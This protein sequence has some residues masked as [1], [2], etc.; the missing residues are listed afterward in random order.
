MSEEAKK[1]HPLSKEGRALREQEK[2][3]GVPNDLANQK[4]TESDAI[5]QEKLQ[6]VIATTNNPP[7][8]QTTAEESTTAVQEANP[9]P[10]VPLSVVQQMINDALKNHAPAP[11]QIIQQTP[12]PI[13]QNI[14]KQE[15]DIDDIPEF[16]DWVVKDRQYEYCDGK[17][18]TANIPV[19][20]SDRIPLQYE[21]KENKSVHVLRYSTNQPSFFKEKQSKEPGSVVVSEILFNYGKLF[22]PAG[23]INLQKFLHIHP[24]KG[25]LFREY[26]PEAKSRDIIE[27]KRLKNKAERLVFEVGEITNRAV[28]GLECPSYVESW[29]PDIVT[30]HVLA[31]AEENPE[32][33]IAYTEDP[34]I[35]M[36]GVIKSA[37]ASGDLIY[38]NYRWLNANR[39][40]ILEVSKNQDEMDEMV[41][42]F[43]GG[44]GR[45]YYEFLVNK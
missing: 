16:R 4:P 24:Y 17:P 5:L 32:K 29:K 43:E 40:V 7:K 8:T 21:N 39:E 6:N 33:Y 30:E 26:D 1:P 25:I 41:R 38:S 45:T 37:L 22:V 31:F 28:A 27:K 10:S 34:G 3:Q 19:D 44:I 9:E 12:A 15:Y 42:Y 18:I 2:T 11:P 20:H 13:I 23:Q 35:K 36:K 14:V